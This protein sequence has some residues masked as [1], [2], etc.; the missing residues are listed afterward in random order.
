[1]PIRQAASRQQHAVGGEMPE[2]PYDDDP[3]LGDE[4]DPEYTEEIFETMKSMGWEPEKLPDPKERAEY[5]EWL[6]NQSDS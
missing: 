6:K 1:M 3:E 4:C 2:L 5:A